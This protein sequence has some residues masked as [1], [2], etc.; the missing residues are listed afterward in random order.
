MKNSIAETKIIPATNGPFEWRSVEHAAKKYNRTKRMI[1]LWCNTGFFA[2]R[3][4]P[5]YRD[6]SGRWWIGLDIATPRTVW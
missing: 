6:S 2:R 4:I 1:R 5:T 3:G